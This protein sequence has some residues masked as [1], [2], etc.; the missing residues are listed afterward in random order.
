MSFFTRTK[1]LPVLRETDRLAEMAGDQRYERRS[2][3]SR[4]DAGG[5]NS[6]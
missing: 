1:R 2:Q 6:E 5:A 4:R 3:K